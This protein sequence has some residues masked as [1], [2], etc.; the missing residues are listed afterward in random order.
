M[1]RYPS[2]SSDPE[3]TRRHCEEAAD[4]SAVALAKAEGG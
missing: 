3:V 1:F 4:L 2:N